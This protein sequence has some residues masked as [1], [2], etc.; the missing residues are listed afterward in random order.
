MD[1]NTNRSYSQFRQKRLQVDYPTWHLVLSKLA[2]TVLKV[3]KH[4]TL[5]EVVAIVSNIG[6]L[7]VSAFTEMPR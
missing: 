6:N 4:F 3:P 7:N 1:I 2:G 5:K